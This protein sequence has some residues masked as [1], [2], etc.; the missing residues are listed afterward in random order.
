MEKLL[1]TVFAVVGFSTI[2]VANNYLQV[3]KLQPEVVVL[4]DCTQDQEAAFDECMSNGCGYFE[5]YFFGAAAWGR[6]M[7]A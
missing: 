3:K 2:S 5:S 7:G 6:C 1:F 4:S